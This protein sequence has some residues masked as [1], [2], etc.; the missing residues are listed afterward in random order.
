MS[1]EI[2]GYPAQVEGIKRR[3]KEKKKEKYNILE[4]WNINY[5]AWNMGDT[6]KK[7]EG[8]DCQNGNVV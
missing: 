1:M 6:V 8:D 4:G 7:Y 5:Y 3:S 2:Y